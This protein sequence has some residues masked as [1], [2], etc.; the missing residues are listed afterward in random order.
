MRSRP[1]NSPPPTGGGRCCSS[2]ACTAAAPR[3]PPAARPARRADAGDPDAAPTATIPTATGNRTPLFRLHDRLLAEAG[4]AWDDWGPLD[5]AASP[6]QAARGRAG[7]ARRRLHRRVRGRIS[8]SRCSRTR[9]S[10]VSCRSGGRCSP[11]S[12]PRRWRCCRSAIRSRSRARS[13]GATGWPR[14]RRCCSGSATCSRPRPATRA[15]P[16]AFLRYDDLVDDWRA[17]ADRL[18]ATLGIDWPVAPEAAAPE[19]AAF[20]SGDLRHHA[21]DPDTRPACLGRGG[22]GGARRPCRGG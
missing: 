9:A 14:R 17:V 2:S 8:G 4:S 12:G 6:P 7:G 21:A 10:A 3:R 11:T 22:L 15:L 16:R 13:P 20:L 19:V 5:G 18:A 1:W